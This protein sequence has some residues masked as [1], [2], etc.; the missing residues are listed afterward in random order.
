MQGSMWLMM[1]FISIAGGLGGF[2]NALMTDNG[3]LFCRSEQTTG[4]AKIFRPGCLGNV[5]IGAV[6]AVVSWGLY[7]PFSAV[8][9]AGTKE[10]LKA[11][12]ASP[13]NIGLSLASFVG[14]MLVGVGGARWLSGEVDKSL[15]RAAAADAAGKTA[16]AEA[17]KQIAMVSPAQALAVARNMAA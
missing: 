13:E 8:F 9:I 16:S 7:G 4:G 12:A 6:G 15:L 3:F 10:A 17:S 1:L 14:A 11:N 2:V 5:F